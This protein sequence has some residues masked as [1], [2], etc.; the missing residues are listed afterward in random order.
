MDADGVAVEGET[1]EASERLF[2]AAERGHE[3]AIGAAIEVFGGAFGGD[4]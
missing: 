2:E 1:F 4:G 3:T